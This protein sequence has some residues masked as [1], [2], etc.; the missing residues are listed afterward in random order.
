M[1]TSF[2]LP[3]ASLRPQGPAPVVRFGTTKQPTGPAPAGQDPAEAKAP[4]A[5]A[6]KPKLK[7]IRSF[8]KGVL[9]PITSVVKYVV[10]NPLQASVYLGASLFAITQFPILGSALA[11]GIFGYGGFQM[12][13]GLGSLVNNL[14][15]GNTEQ[16]NNAASKIGRGV[17]DV[18]FSYGSAFKSVKA[19]KGSFSLATAKSELTLLQR[20]SAFGRQLQ[21]GATAEELNALPKGFKDLFTQAKTR[22]TNLFNKESYTLPKAGNTEDITTL[23]N[24]NREN[25]ANLLEK[26]KGW[27]GVE[28]LQKIVNAE[29]LKGPTLTEVPSVAAQILK[30]PKLASVL[31][32]ILE[33][34]KQVV[35]GTEVLKDIKNVLIG[36][37]NTEG[38][39][40]NT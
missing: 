20:L 25:V 1:P 8:V 5:K 9:E 29:A 39:Q 17:F 21:P 18:A 3:A 6:N 16:A 24:N 14:R 13:T 38:S 37:G 23:I 26:Y 28:S 22:F 27:W 40:Q 4:V 11:L 10:N 31:A 15:K 32:R 35:Q 36:S 33:A 2:S 34:E 19:L 7:L 12:A 30:D